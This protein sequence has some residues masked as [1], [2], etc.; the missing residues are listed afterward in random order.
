MSYI[1]RRAREEGLPKNIVLKEALQVLCLEHLY[2]FPES[3]IIIFQGGTCLRLLYGGPRYSEDLDFVVSDMQTL[4]GLFKKVS[5][6]VERMGPLFE[7]KTWMRV[8]KESKNLVR[9]KLYFESL[10]DKESSSVSIE[11]A[12]Y[13]AYTSQLLPLKIPAGYPSTPLI[14]VK[15]ETEEELL[16][17]KINALATRKYL[18]GRD[19]FDIWLLRSKGIAVN[20]DMVKK[21]FKDYSTPKTNLENKILQFNEE[22]IRHDLENY[23]PRNYREKFKKEGYKI[24]LEAAKTAVRQVDEQ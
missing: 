3:D 18:K 21:K 20:T 24:M 8:Q 17:D 22:K 9:W 10:E 11:F 16:A 23:L 19:I 6:S 7:G 14:L 13:P 2:T 1:I 5:S 12:N 4:S 15:T